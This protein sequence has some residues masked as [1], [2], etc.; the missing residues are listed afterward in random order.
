MPQ[1]GKLF[2][3][4]ADTNRL[5]IINILAQ[6]DLCVCDLQF[7]LG[8]SQPFISRHL[9]C[10]RRVGLVKDRR[11]GARICYSLT[12]DGAMGEALRTLLHVA[13]QDSMT[14]QWDLRKLFEQSGAGRIR[15]GGRL[16]DTEP[17]SSLAA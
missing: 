14:F 11:E 3:A 5:R 16:T 17:F 2:K 12:M 10:L 7:V 9:A 15:S 13:A 8:L 1:I 4:L 6:C